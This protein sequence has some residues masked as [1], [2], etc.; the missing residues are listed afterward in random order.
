[1]EE[2]QF[3][4]ILSSLSNRDLIASGYEKITV[5]GLTAQTLDLTTSGKG[6]GA[7]YA[8][9][10]VESATTTGV[11]MRYLI[12]DTDPTTTD[13]MAL[14]YLDL[15]DIK[16]KVNLQQF[17]IIAVSGSHTIHVQYYQ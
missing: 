13:G 2:L 6:L 16:N 3:R 9:I 8:E 17:K 11:I 12:T 7:T 14:S 15:Y 4:S 5:T 1:M 10:R